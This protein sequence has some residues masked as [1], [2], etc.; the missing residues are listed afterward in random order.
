MREVK[1]RCGVGWFVKMC[2]LAAVAQVVVRE[3]VRVWA[4]SLHWMVLLFRCCVQR[5]FGD[6]ASVVKL[7]DLVGFGEFDWGPNTDWAGGV[8]QSLSCASC[9]DGMPWV[10]LTAGRAL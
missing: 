9:R 4:E 8:E 6:E 10:V 1:P 2:L 5:F 7:K 3:C